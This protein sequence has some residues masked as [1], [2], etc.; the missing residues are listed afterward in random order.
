MGSSTA[1]ETTINTST[2]S[3][4]TI[5]TTVTAT[6][7]ELTE[8]SLDTGEQMDYF[9]SDNIAD[10]RTN[11]V[12]QPIPASPMT[13]ATARQ[14]TPPTCKSVTKFTFDEVMESSFSKGT[15]KEFL[16]PTNIFDLQ[17]ASKSA[18]EKYFGVKSSSENS[19]NFTKAIRIFF[20]FRHLVKYS[21][22][23]MI[24]ISSC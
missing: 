11:T 8:G 18:A 9:S 5:V 10:G 12:L 1:S 3:S 7:G 15:S 21:T 20:I 17:V 23:L 19:T 14:A 22:F 4:N 16:S 13:P 2:D 24:P 6:D